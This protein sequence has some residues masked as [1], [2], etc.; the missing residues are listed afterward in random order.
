MLRKIQH[1]GFSVPGEIPA[2]RA[3]LLDLP[4]PVVFDTA[5]YAT[6]LEAI[7]LVGMGGGMFPAD[8]KVRVSHGVHA[9]VINGVECEPGITIDQAILLQHS[10]WVIA[11]AEASARAVGAKRI[12]L[13]VKK[14][15]ELIKQLRKLYS[16]D[17]LTMPRSYP[18]GAEKLILRKLLGRMPPPGTLPFHLGFLVQNVAS[19]RAAGRALL[20]GIPAVE[21]PLTLIAPDADFY[22]NLIV[23]VGMTFNELLQAAGC[24]YD[25]DSRILVAGGLMMGRE[26]AADERVTLGTTSLLVLNR[27]RLEKEETNCIRCGAC[28]DACP[29]KLHPIALVDMIRNGRPHTA[30]FK[31]QLKEC[32]LCGACATVCPARIPL[33]AHLRE[34]KKCL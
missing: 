29:L 21:R 10:R 7:G 3:L 24:P 18:A 34:G 31:S 4:A 17:L 32:F 27:R 6:F 2:L 13:A 25:P 8:R 15:P 33:A 22:Q 1:P 23:P 28:Y 16:F 30:A 26:V 14:K 11:G 20:D 9:L 12:I 5:D 19:L